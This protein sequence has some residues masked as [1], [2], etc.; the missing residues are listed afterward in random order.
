MPDPQPDPAIA[1]AVPCYNEAAAIA[2][3][4]DAW[5]RSLPE[6]EIVVFDNNSTD[7]TGTIARELGVR[8][9][10]VPRQGKGHAVRAIFREFADRDA[11]ILVDGDGTYPAESAR[12][13]L[14]P[15]LKGF[16]DMTI[17]ARRPIE[18]ANAMSPVRGIGN[19]LIRATFA[20][21]IGEGPGDLLSGYR[22]FGGKAIRML[23]LR[24]SGFEIEAQIACLATANGLRI[25]EIA[26]PYY[27]RI[28][29]T[30]SKLSAPRDGVRIVAT[31]ARL[32]LRTRPWIILGLFS[33]SFF[34]LYLVFHKKSL[35]VGAAINAIVG[36]GSLIAIRSLGIGD[37]DRVDPSRTREDYPDDSTAE[38]LPD[39]HRI[40]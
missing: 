8:V 16:A 26:I 15:I 4:I 37:R 1:V 9:I 20:I 38:R 11:I 18:G 3:V 19:I 7:G 24:S 29:G 17:G 21:L 35:L 13:L 23:D 28:E 10:E 14:E 34:A 31:I 25:V 33:L 32:G 5:R 6:A 27:P 2:A 30:V 36:L 12:E 22:V 39:S 40:G